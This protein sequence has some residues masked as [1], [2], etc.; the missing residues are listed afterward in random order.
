MIA[1]AGAG[2]VAPDEGV[3]AEVLAAL[4]VACGVVVLASE[5]PGF[6]ITLPSDD[7]AG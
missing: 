3:V 4:G 6:G 1:G 5:G 7:A 2:V